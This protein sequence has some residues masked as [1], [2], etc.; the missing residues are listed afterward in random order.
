MLNNI[1][2][3]EDMTKYPDIGDLIQ[4]GVDPW[5]LPSEQRHVVRNWS[6][7]VSSGIV[8]HVEPFGEGEC[9]QG[10]PMSLPQYWFDLGWAT[11]VSTEVE[12]P[13]ENKETESLVG[14][15]I[16]STHLP[17]TPLPPGDYVIEDEYPKEDFNGTYSFY[18]IRSKENGEEYVV[19][20]RWIESGLI[21]IVEDRIGRI[22]RVLGTGTTGLVGDY[23]EV[24]GYEENGV[25][26]VREVGEKD[27]G[28]VVVEKWFDLGYIEMLEGDED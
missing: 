3:E 17:R 22:I 25:W 18:F 15:T 19:S 6:T 10:D 16:K 13:R 2:E 7:D 26:G 20:S 12:Q 5:G 4:V 11:V 14:R 1:I 9:Y 24:V 8:Y 23:Y 28:L 21:E 27:I